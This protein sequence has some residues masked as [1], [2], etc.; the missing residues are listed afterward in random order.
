MVKNFELQILHKN[1]FFLLD[2]SGYNLRLKKLKAGKVQDKKKTRQVEI[3]FSKIVNLINITQKAHISNPFRSTVKIFP[4]QKSNITHG[5]ICFGRITTLC[6][7]C[8]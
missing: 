7:Y 5:K 3:L 6:I 4:I 8:H 2:G 1:V